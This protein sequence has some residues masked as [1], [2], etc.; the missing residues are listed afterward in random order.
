MS[1]EEKR[2]I[3]LQAAS[4]V[5]LEYGPNKM[6]LDDIAKKAGMAKTSLY[7]YFKDKNEIIRAIISSFTDQLVEQ[8][9]VAVS[10]AD[11]AEEKMIALSD[12]RYRYISAKASRASR[13]IITEFRSLAGI[14]EE[15]KEHYLKVQK[16]LIED[17]LRQGIDRGEMKPIP[18]LDLI[19]LI[20]ISSMFG[21]D[22]TFAFYGQDEHVLEAIKQMVRIF[23]AGLRNVS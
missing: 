22:H 12:A 10:T 15:E 18:D 19:S 23:F 13:D 16:D 8:V 7:Y 17:I 11:T 14:F 4:D 3:L 20:M 1:K 9:S 2:R 5:L 21:C 6:T